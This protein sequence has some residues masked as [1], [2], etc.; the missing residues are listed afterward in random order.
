M[1]NKEQID[2]KHP[3]AKHLNAER[4]LYL[5]HQALN[6]RIDSIRTTTQSKSGHPTSCL[7]IADIVSTIFFNF[8]RYDLKNPKY[9]NND[10]VILSKGHAIPLIYA[11]W[12]QFGVISDE[13]LM[14]LRN[15][16]SPLEGHPTPRF[17]Y[18]EA[19]TGSLGQGLSIGLGMA[20][21][22]RLDNFDFTTYVLMGDGEIAEGSIWEAAELAAFYKVDNLIGFVDCN[23]LGQAGP[24]LHE[25]QVQ[26]YVNKFQA[27]GWKALSIDGHDISQIVDAI[28]IAKSTKNQ[29]TMIIA[30]TFK[31]YGLDEIS[32]ELGWHGKPLSQESAEKAITRLKIKFK[33]EAAFKPSFACAPLMPN[34]SKSKKANSA[35]ACGSGLPTIATS[36]TRAT[37]GSMDKCNPSDLSQ[38]P[39][40]KYFEKNALLSTRKAFGYALQSLGQ[41]NPDVVALD[42]DVSNSTFSEFFAKKFPERFIQCFIAEQNMIGVSAGLQ[43]RG[44]IPFAATF[45]AFLTRA[46]DQLRMAGIGGNVLRICGSHCGVSIGQDGPSQMG[47][48]DIAMF[49]AIPN[50][51]ILYPSDA[52]CAYKLMNLCA[53]Y[54]DG[55]SYLRT[56]RADTQIIYDS[57]E[58][59][60]IGK[61]KVLRQSNNDTC[62]IVAAGI[63]LHE[64][65]N[66]YDLLKAEGIFASVIDLYSIKPMD[67]ETILKVAKSSNNKIISVE[68]HYLNGGIG[69]ML[70]GQIINSG[71]KQKMLG[72]TKI[73]R[74]GTPEE[75]M[76]DAGIDADNIIKAVKEFD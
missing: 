70:A 28:D 60:E 10:R 45:A 57:S 52:V 19:A 15:F 69:Q 55:I 12:K 26:N 43:S 75:L 9:P 1:I 21:A 4:L 23:R 13:E 63:T 36:A 49:N 33:E 38:D 50:S 46:F 61:C 48:E 20:L 66:A 42:A 24:T 64:A 71:I 5:K 58:T 30:K 34:D 65:L 37:V 29:S 67:I 7:S 68:D 59:F 14:S 31:G 56:T 3:D 32:N 27:F 41:N 74:S 40:K 53:M 6:L 2:A 35:Q 8:L 51:I 44:K 73:S 54:N 22:A 17:A 72:V 62:C 11:A 47:L 39:N 18:N 16:N 25:H 76:H